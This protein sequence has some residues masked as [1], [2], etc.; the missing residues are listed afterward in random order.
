MYNPEHLLRIAE[1]A[2]N[3]AYCRYSGFAVGAALVTESGIIYTGCNIENASYP[4][5]ICAERV[6]FGKA[7]SDGHTKFR[8]I[9]ISGAQKGKQAEVPCS[10]CGMCRQFM[11]EFCQ[12]DFQIILAEDK[13]YLMKDLLPVR[14]DFR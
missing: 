11:S 9:A 6:A 13:I 4:A 3:N 7:I 5:G 14:F 10:P 2:R 12:D 8:A 1:Q